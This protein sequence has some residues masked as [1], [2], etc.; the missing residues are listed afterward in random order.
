MITACALLM[1]VSILTLWLPFNYHHSRAGT[2]VFAVVYGLVS[3]GFISLMIPCAFKLGSLETLGQRFGTHQLVL[4]SRSVSIPHLRDPY[5]MSYWER[6]AH[7][8]SIQHVDGIACHGRYF[9]QARPSRFLRP[10][11]LCLCIDSGGH[12]TTCSV[13]LLPRKDAQ[14]VEDLMGVVSRLAKNFERLV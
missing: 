11:D 13:N 5:T 1:G 4:A 6:F 7:A 3:G 10:A 2:I 9:E 8:N 14:D 12:G